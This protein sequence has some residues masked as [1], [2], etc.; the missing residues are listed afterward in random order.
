MGLLTP[1]LGLIFW[2]TITFLIFLFILRMWGWP[3]VIKG[4]KKREESIRNSLLAAENAKKEMEKLKAGNEELLAQAREER[5]NILKQARLSGNQLIEEARQEARQ[6]ANKIILKAKEDIIYEK[7]RVLKDLQNQM[8]QMSLDIAQK[9]L[10]QE[11]KDTKT[12]EEFIAK[13]IEKISFK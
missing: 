6:E 10:Q 2:T 8:G 4:L 13:Q 12:S 1:E 9:I 5:D 7:D 11:V 3:V